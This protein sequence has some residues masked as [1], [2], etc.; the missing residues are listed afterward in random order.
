MTERI[1]AIGDIHGQK[2]MLDGALARIEADGGAGARTVFLGDYVDRGPDSRGVID[3][4][5]RGR[6]AGRDWVFVKGN[7]DRMF[8]RFLDS[9]ERHDDRI[10][11]GKSWV[12][13]NLGGEETLASYGV[14]GAATME[15]EALLQAVERAVPDSHRAFLK[16]LALYHEQGDFL[17]VHAGIR[18]GLPLKWQQED[19]L[20][21]IR[22]EFLSDGRDFGHFVVH[23][24]TPVEGPDLRSNRLNLDT[25]A[26]YGRP[27]SVAVFEG[28]RI[29]QLTETGRQPL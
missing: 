13:P 15:P 3:T 19:D 11:S 18:P 9:G 24:H 29:A 20:L 10:K 7:H 14:P 1:Y 23:G 27:L 17:F 8:E 12:T 2:A 6:D 4:F 16:D 5:L 28:G 25:G 22:D 21:W 26:G